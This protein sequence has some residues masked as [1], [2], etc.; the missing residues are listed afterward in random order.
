MEN[1]NSQPSF[2]LTESGAPVKNPLEK[3]KKAAVDS[4]SQTSLRA[5]MKDGTEWSTC[6]DG[7]C[8]SPDGHKGRQM[9]AGE[10]YCTVALH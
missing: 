2:R 8:T 4:E 10:W 3:K 1:A 6:P 7:K 5:T 9:K